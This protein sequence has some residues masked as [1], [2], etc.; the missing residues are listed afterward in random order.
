MWIGSAR[1]FPGYRSR[2]G[3]FV[4]RRSATR[5]FPRPQPERWAPSAELAGAR[6][7]ARRSARACQELRVQEAQVLVREV[8]VGLEV[9]VGLPTEL[10]THPNGTLLHEER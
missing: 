6:G 10:D 2:R 5:D 4:S 3:G 9:D 7:G 8:V 1:R